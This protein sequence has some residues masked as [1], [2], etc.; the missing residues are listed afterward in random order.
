MDKRKLSAIPRD[1]ATVEMIEMAQQLGGLSY[2]VTTRMVEDNKIL[3][4]NFFEVSRLKSGKTEAVFRTFLSKNDYITQD[5]NVS[6]VKWKTASFCMMNHFQLFESH[7]NSEENRFDYTK[8]IFIWSKEDLATINGFFAEYLSAEHQYDPWTAINNFQQKI[9]ADRLHA[10]HKKETDSIDTLMAAVKD[11][12]EEFVEWSFDK[13]MGFSRYLIYQEVEKGIANCE[14]THCGK[15]ALVD[16]NRIRLRNN[17]KGNCPFCGSPVTIKA[18]GKLPYRTTDERW[19]VYIDR[20]EKGFIWRSFHIYREMHKYPEESYAHKRISQGITECQR[21]FYLFEKGIPKCDLYEYTEYK[22]SGK[23]RWCHGEGKICC[24]E[25]ILYPVNLPQA[26]EHTPMKYSALEILSR[27]LPTVS[28]R[29][30]SG[31]KAYMKYP[32]LEWLIKMGLNQIAKGVLSMSF[33]GRTGKL[34]CNGETIY[35]ILGINKVNTRTLQQIDGSY[36]E[37]RLLQV[38]QKIGLQIKP[39]QLREYYE[40]F[41]CNTDL[42]KQS[43]RKVSLHKLSK[44]ITKESENYPIGKAGE[45]CRYSYMRYKER[46]DPRVERK[47]NTAADWIEYIGWCR[48][49]KYDLDNMFIYMP[50]NFKKVHDRTAKEYQA[51]KDEQTRKRKAEMEKRIKKSL[52]D[53]AGLPAM[54]MKAK[55]LTIILPKSGDE[56]KEEGRVLHHCV[57]TYVERVAKGETMILFVRKEAEPD[58]PYFTLEYRG[59]KVV[60]CRGRNNCGMSK[61]VQAFVKAFEAKM[62]EEQ[63]SDRSRKAG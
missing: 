59:G 61:D 42:L 1:A 29:Y 52:K 36:D 6:K 2:V 12:P 8:T 49:M 53:A 14:C 17:E 21:G 56:I 3:L 24:G 31:I 55:G 9:M 62:Q 47:R 41:E 10:R 26:W 63:K 60:Q 37:L 51:Y 11:V 40:A 13:A 38:A 46:E 27:N 35:Q 16:R 28:M 30:E 32:F 50:T 54:M 45:C 22:Q 57:G 48:E 44:Y 7:W 15:I 34:D 18:K 23:T 33:S 20:T 19:T 39:E 58:V 43:G 5:L 25:C 4:L